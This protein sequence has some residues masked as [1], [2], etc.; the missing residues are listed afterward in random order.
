MMDAFTEGS[1]FS[2]TIG[3]GAVVSLLIL[4]R[5]LPALVV[6]ETIIVGHCHVVFTSFKLVALLIY[7][8]GIKMEKKG[9]FNIFDIIY[10]R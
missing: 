1:M 7:V 9:I 10:C 3:G 8:L 6:F 4:G 5:V 2:S